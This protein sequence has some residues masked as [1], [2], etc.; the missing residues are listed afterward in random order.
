MRSPPHRMALPD[1]EVLGAIRKVDPRRR[2]RQVEAWLRE[3]F[4]TAWP[5]VQ[6]RVERIAGDV[7]G[8]CHPTRRGLV[9]RVR[10]GLSPETATETLHH[11]WAHAMT[12]PTPHMERAHRRLHRAPHPDH[13]DEFWI[14]YGR[15]WCAWY[16]AD[17]WR[18]SGGY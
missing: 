7:D 18:R 12:Y 16:E 3:G 11:E 9:L 2:L 10:K 15:I 13:P 1:D 14:A 6:V 4:P 17:G 8:D 5:V